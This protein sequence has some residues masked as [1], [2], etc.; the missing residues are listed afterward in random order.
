MYHH[1]SVF[2]VVFFG[3]L[4]LALFMFSTIGLLAHFACAGIMSISPPTLAAS[5]V[6]TCVNH[7]AK[8]DHVLLVR[9]V[10][11]NGSAIFRS[12]CILQI[13]MSTMLYMDLL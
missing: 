10:L 12:I 13:S 4:D 11:V 6:V 7:I 8:H 9:E 3:T 1:G 5:V 2:F